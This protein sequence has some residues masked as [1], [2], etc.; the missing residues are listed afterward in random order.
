MTVTA[1]GRPPYNQWGPYGG[2]P[3]SCQE[4]EEMTAV[5]RQ[6]IL[7]LSHVLDA[8]ST[9]SLGE[10]DHVEHAPAVLVREKPVRA[11]NDALQRLLTLTN[12]RLHQERGEVH[13]HPAQGLE[14]RPRP[15]VSR[16]GDHVR[17]AERLGALC[18]RSNE[19]EGV[20]FREIIRAGHQEK[21]ADLSLLVRL[22][23]NRVS[24]GESGQRFRVLGTQRGV[25]RLP[26]PHYG[27]EERIVLPER[28]FYVEGWHRLIESG[29]DD[30][31]LPVQDGQGLR[32][33]LLV[34]LDGVC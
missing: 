30:A 2:S 25:N 32:Q 18:D 19:F 7:L 9:P 23:E 6:P 15:L 13:A 11:R 16:L 22:P 31:P 10:T 27:V 34:D 4:V 28:G 14:G 5:H 24:F 17:I 1:S 21:V 8:R 20:L 26:D 3:A 33:Y 29:T 12:G